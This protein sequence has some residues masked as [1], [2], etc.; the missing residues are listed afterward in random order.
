VSLVAYLYKNST[1]ISL[2]G[3]RY[4]VPKK[5]WRQMVY[6]DKKNKS[7]VFM[8]HYGC[9]VEENV[10]SL[11][12]KETAELICRLCGIEIESE[13][14][15]FRK[16]EG[17]GSEN[18]ITNTGSFAWPDDRWTSIVRL[19]K[20]LY[21]EVNLDVTPT[22]GACGGGMDDKGQ[23][24]CSD[25]GKDVHH[26][27]SCGGAIGEDDYRTDEN[28]ETWCQSCH[29]EAFCCCEICENYCR[30]DD[31]Q[32]AN[33]QSV[34]DSCLSDHF[35]KCNG[36]DEYFMDPDS[37]RRRRGNGGGCCTEACDGEMYCDNCRSEDFSS[38]RKCEEEFAND[39]LNSDGICAEC[40]KNKEEEDKAREAEEAE[41][42]EETITIRPGE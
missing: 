23:L 2:S 40:V 28:G 21:P 16:R 41:E 39:D 27:V 19:D 4:G 33:N 24:V 35:T 10:H 34:C 7:A 31:V 22:C 12:R 38:C 42:A 20:S 3:E 37:R 17:D 26:C 15:W 18:P 30:A 32:S 36:C 8:R 25:C 5:L 1:P 9:A 29:D 11:L 6:V 13:P 14:H